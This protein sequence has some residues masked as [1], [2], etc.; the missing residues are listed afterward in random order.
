MRCVSLSLWTKHRRRD[1][2][3]SSIVIFTQAVDYVQQSMILKRAMAVRT[4]SNL[5]VAGLAVAQDYRRNLDLP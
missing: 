5:S 2:I 3:P 1:G 4:D